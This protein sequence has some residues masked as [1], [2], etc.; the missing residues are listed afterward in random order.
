MHAILQE[1]KPTR[2]R[3]GR[4]AVRTMGALSS[5]TKSVN[6][7]PKSTSSTHR[8]GK[9]TCLLGSRTCVPLVVQRL[10]SLVHLHE[11][12]FNAHPPP[13]TPKRLRHSGPLLKSVPLGFPPKTHP[14][15]RFFSPERLRPIEVRQLISVQLGQAYAIPHPEPLSR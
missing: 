9:A 12:L 3:L 7:F 11:R 14:H 5:P 13:K 2:G 6:L 4:A 15:A 8:W 1:S 10:K